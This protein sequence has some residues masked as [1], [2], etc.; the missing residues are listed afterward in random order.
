MPNWQDYVGGNIA[1]AKDYAGKNKKGKIVSMELIEVKGKD[2]TQQTRLCA[3]VGGI[4]KAIPFNRTACEAFAKKY[5]DDYNKWLN[6][7]ITVNSKD[8]GK[9]GDFRYEWSILA[10]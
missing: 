9:T 2:N 8:T 4:D 3:M 10:S 1:K 7:P 5:G 6:K